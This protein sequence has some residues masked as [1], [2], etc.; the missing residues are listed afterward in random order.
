MIDA[1]MP[2]GGNIPA[3]WKET[4]PVIFAQTS[5]SELIRAFR[6]LRKLALLQPELTAAAALA[7]VCAERIQTMPRREVKPLAITLAR[8]G[9]LTIRQISELTSVSPDTLSRAGIRVT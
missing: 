5:H 7:R 3:I 1:L 8:Q 9:E 2:P 6:Q 4:L